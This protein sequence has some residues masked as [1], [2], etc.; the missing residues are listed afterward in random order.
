MTK[1]VG[2]ISD[3]VEVCTL[4]TA[5]EAINSSDDSLDDI[6]ILPLV[7]A[8]NIVGLGNGSVVEDGI[9]GTRVIHYIQPVAHV[10]ALA[11]DRE[12]LAMANVV[13]EQRNQ[14]LRELVR[15]IVVAAVCHDSRHA[16]GIVESANKVV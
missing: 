14:L 8:S 6:Y 12:R 10:L 9:D 4:R 16:V 11:I 13:D 5:E 15:T 3:E 1:T 7:E 2:H